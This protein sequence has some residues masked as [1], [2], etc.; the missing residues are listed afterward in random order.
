M[1]EVKIVRKRKLGGGHQRNA[2]D[3]KKKW[4]RQMQG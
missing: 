2:A 1:E 3:L 4:S